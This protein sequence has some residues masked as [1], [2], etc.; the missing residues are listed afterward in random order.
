MAT[1]KLG[2]TEDNMTIVNRS[3]TLEQAQ[4]L[5][6]QKQAETNQLA[7]IGKQ[8]LAANQQAQ[9]QAAKS[10][11]LEHAYDTGVNHGAQ[12]LY[13]GL[14]KQGAMQDPMN[15]GGGVT[16]AEVEKA[17]S[18]FGNKIDMRDIE[19]MRRLDTLDTSNKPNY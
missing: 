12:D 19:L 6:D 14:A 11:M 5:L 2:Y 9:E 13:D 10:K 7:E 17:R 16:N 18:M 3:K 15:Q 4:G 1:N 8:A